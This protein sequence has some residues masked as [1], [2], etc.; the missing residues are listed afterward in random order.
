MIKQLKIF[1]HPFMY[2]V[3]GALPLMA[4]LG[5]F[6]IKIKDLEAQTQQIIY[7]QKKKLW[8]EKKQAEEKI[9]LSHLR[10]ADKEYVEKYLESLTFHQLEIQRLQALFYSN[11]EQ[12]TLNQRLNTL[13]TANKL[14]FN[15]QN[16][17]RVENIQETELTQTHTVEMN[18][19]DLKTTL[20]L[21]E[22][23]P[24]H[25]PQF[26]IKIFDLTKKALSESQETYIISLGL[27]KREMI[28]E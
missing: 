26:I 19:Q 23:F 13:Q 9:I 14:R 5:Y 8:T 17:Q 2:F 6:F 15:E 20:S 3:Y 16:F 24:I 27:L 21:I 28:D 25:S 11:C 22:N 18:E 12:G 7:L 1:K 4:A 10:D